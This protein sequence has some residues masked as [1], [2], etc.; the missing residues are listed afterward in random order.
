MYRTAIDEL[1]KW[2]SSEYRKP[3][4][5]NGVRQVGKTWLLKEFGRQNYQNTV[6]V[7]FEENP[8]YKSFFDTTKD[9]ER[10]LPNLAVAKKQTIRPGDTL[11][12]FDEIQECPDAL[13]SLKYFYEN[14]PEYHIVCAGSLLGV[15]LSR[16]TSFP[17][18]KVE[19]LT[20]RPMT[21]SEFLIAGG[22]ENLAS[23]LDGIREIEPIPEAF[24]GPLC[25]KL[26]MYY[27]IGGMPEAIYAWTKEHDINQVRKIQQ[28]ILNA[29]TRDFAK[30]IQPLSDV[31]K[32]MYIW[33]SIPSQLAKENRKFLYNV[34]KEGARAREYETA[35]QWLCDANLVWKVFRIRSPELPISSQKDLSA[36]KIYLADVGLLGCMSV[37]D[38]SVIA[39]GDAVFS[40]FKGALAENYVLEAIIGQFEG[41]PGYMSSLNP[42]YEIDF[43]IQRKNQIIPIEVKSDRHVTG[44][45]LK[46]YKELYGD[47]VKI[48]V[49][50]SLLNLKL[51][52]DVL[53]IPLFMA[54]H[55]ARLLDLVLERE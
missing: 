26:K 16:P 55:S 5:V 38:P 48:R 44:K 33:E 18:G 10:I 53:N 37:L 8:E 45:S 25:E 50:Y 46:K 24:F 42:K 29:Y 51:D 54:D 47:S 28:N 35:L 7:N 40:T 9:I 2:K 13:N 21:F 4:I 22:D 31:P 43:I 19:F 17:V 39:E 3:L 30:H 36:F 6:Y 34:V 27:I 23:Y 14:G 15:A 20:L 1:R 41:N 12:I 52:D 49:R 32:V 11:L